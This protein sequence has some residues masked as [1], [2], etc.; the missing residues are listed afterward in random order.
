M[1]DS[2]QFDLA[3]ITG[4]IVVDA[5]YAGF[6]GPFTLAGKSEMVLL[7][8]KRLTRQKPIYDCTGG[9]SCHHRLECRSNSTCGE[10]WPQATAVGVGSEASCPEGHIQDTGGDA[11]WY[12]PDALAYDNKPCCP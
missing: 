5:T 10:A 1:G 9:C 3:T 6:K 12:D 7:D 4:D 2:H 8:G 11:W